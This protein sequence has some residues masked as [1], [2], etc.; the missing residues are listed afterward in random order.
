MTISLIDVVSTLGLV[1]AIAG[2]ILV[3]YQKRSGLVIWFISSMFWIA[4]N[5]LP[6]VTFNWQQVI[7]YLIYS[8]LNVHG[9]WNWTRIKRKAQNESKRSV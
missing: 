3:N 8:A 1:G 5:F 9:F 2:N 7:M 4:Y 6:D